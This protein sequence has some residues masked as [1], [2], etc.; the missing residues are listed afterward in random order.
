MPDI[1]TLTADS[2]IPSVVI[3]AIA[4]FGKLVIDRRLARIDGQIAD[5]SKTT[6]QICGASLSIKTE[7][8]NE[9]R[10]ELVDFRTAVEKWDDFLQGAPFDF[11][12]TPPEKAD[13]A[14]LYKRDR[15][16]FLEV[17]LAVVRAAT[18]LRDKQ[19]E[20]RLMKA[21]IEIRIRY[22][23]LINGAL[24]RLIDL[25]AALRPIGQKLKVF[26]ESGDM[27]FAPSEKDRQDNLA[28]QQRMTDEVGAFAQEFLKVYA[29]IYPQL[30]ALKEDINAYIYRPIT[31]SAIDLE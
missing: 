4:Y 16:L 10:H 13:I 29:A 24:M 26:E 18:Y 19:L 8:R 20:D 17:K 14:D 31:R 27:R 28:L 11:S 7:L 2:L 25:Q 30:A 12:M 1:W 6:E 21:I 9:E 3:G 22:Y 15:R 23:P 5:M